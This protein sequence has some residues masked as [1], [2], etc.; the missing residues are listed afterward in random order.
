ML[1]LH[2]FFSS[3]KLSLPLSN[4]SMWPG[5][6]IF[7]R[8]IKFLICSVTERPKMM[9]R[10]ANPAAI[11]RGSKWIW[12]ETSHFQNTVAVEPRLWTVTKISHVYC[13]IPSSETL[14]LSL[15]IYTVPEGQPPG[16][17]SYNPRYHFCWKF[18][19]LEVI[20]TNLKV[21]HIFFKYPWISSYEGSQFIWWN[22]QIV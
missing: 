7:D 16:I 6:S 22:T 12:T 13:N 20:D 11:C 17:S 5:T 1:W 18:L 9:D 14:W 3:Q 19:W 2:F 21:I 10:I 15:N 4:H 8:S